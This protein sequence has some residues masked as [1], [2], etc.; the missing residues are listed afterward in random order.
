M[1]SLR[2]GLSASL[3][4]LSIAGG[5]TNFFSSFSDGRLLLKKYTLS[6]GINRCSLNHY[7][8]EGFYGTVKNWVAKNRWSVPLKAYVMQKCFLLNERDTQYHKKYTFIFG[9][10]PTL[11]NKKKVCCFSA[12]QGR[13]H[14]QATLH[15]HDISQLQ[16]WPKIGVK[17]LG[18]KD[19]TNSSKHTASLISALNTWHR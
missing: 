10:R 19:N 17:R 8:G 2:G 11:Y 5:G 18:S 1:S 15:I 16:D 3:L 7:R 14:V 12:S 13:K 4:L 9:A 6:F